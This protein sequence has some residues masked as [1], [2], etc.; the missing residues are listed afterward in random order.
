MME[1]IELN[2]DIKMPMLGFGTFLNNGDEC[3]QFV[4]QAIRHGYCLIDIAEAYGN[5]E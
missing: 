4:F 1:Y 2:K 5:E 3:E